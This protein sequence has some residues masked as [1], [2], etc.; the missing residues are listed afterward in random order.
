MRRDRMN[1]QVQT[2]IGLYTSMTRPWD[3]AEE[4]AA[5][6]VERKPA[7]PRRIRLGLLLSSA[8]GTLATWL[9]GVKSMLP[10]GWL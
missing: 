2:A 10:D 8:T 4:T 9:A 5:R 3:G 7:P 6:E 1:D